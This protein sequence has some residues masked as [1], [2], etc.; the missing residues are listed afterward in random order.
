[1]IIILYNNNNIFLAQLISVS[2]LSSSLY[3]YGY[4]SDNDYD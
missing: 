2:T 4:D 1:M 3:N